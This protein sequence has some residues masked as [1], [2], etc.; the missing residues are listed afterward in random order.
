[1]AQCFCIEDRGVAAG[2]ACQVPCGFRFFA[3]EQPYFPLE[4]MVFARIAGL[5]KAVGHVS[6]KKRG[7][8]LS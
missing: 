7:R 3:A 8:A 6:R 1:M 4:G 5:Q 2:L